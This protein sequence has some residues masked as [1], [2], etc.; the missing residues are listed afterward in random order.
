MN[1]PEKKSK[2]K[3]CVH[4]AEYGVR[5]LQ[6]KVEQLTHKREENIDSDLHCD[7]LGIME[8]AVVRVCKIILGGATTCRN[9]KRSPPSTFAPSN[10]LMVSEPQALIY[11][12]ISCNT[13]H[14]I[15]K[16][17]I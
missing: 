14:G 8:R 2:L 1:T 10:Y 13:N 4:E 11:F 16:A 6:Q 12:S 15:Y 5:Q 3:K 17:A 9:H 7:L